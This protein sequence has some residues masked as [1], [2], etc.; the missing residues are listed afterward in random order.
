MEVDVPIQDLEQCAQ[1]YR[2]AE[3]IPKVT[4]ETVC[5]GLSGKDSCFV[6]Y[7]STINILT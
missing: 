4:K 6:S 3:S 1:N 2:K 7:F 5:A